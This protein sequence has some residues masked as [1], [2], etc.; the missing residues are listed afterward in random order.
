MADLT[1]DG[2]GGT[3]KCR[4]CDDLRPTAGELSQGWML[5]SPLDRWE[6]VVRVRHDE[7]YGP[8][9]VNTDKTGPEY[10]WRYFSSSKVTA[11][12]PPMQF[13]G[14]PEIRIVE[15]PWHDGAMYAVPTLST[16][17]PDRSTVL[18]EAHFAGRG[19][20]W[21]VS[22]RPGGGDLVVTEF[23]TK[24]KARAALRAA[25]RAH[26]KALGVKVVSQPTRN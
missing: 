3:L 13:H 5:R 25:A 8:V 18:V 12:P 23:D 16:V 26:A 21:K 1:C 6:K 14:V 20:G 2:C 9:L 15:T 22:D 19:K 10:A 7:K 17:N 4:I 24:A 11:T